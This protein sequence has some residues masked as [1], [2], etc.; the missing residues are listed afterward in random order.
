MVAFRA[1][2]LTAVLG[3]ASQS[4]GALASNSSAPHPHQ[5]LI[6]RLKL[7]GKLDIKLSAEDLEVIESGQLWMR[8]GEKDS[9]GSGVG[10]RD[11]AAPMD[12]VFGQISD[13]QGY[14][15]KVPMLNSL[16]VYDRKE[17]SGIVVEKATYVIRVIPGYNFEYYVKHYASQKEGIVLFY[18]D[19]DRLGDFNDMQGKWYLEPHPTKAGW[20]RVYY[21][22]DLMLFGYAPKIVK[23][24]LTSKGLQS[25]I[26]WVK[27]ESE[28]RAPKMVA[29]AFVLGAGALAG[30]KANAPALSSPEALGLDRFSEEMPLPS[31]GHYSFAFGA[32]VAA[33]LVATAHVVA[34]RRQSR[35]VRA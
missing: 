2:V 28:K 22:C 27:A 5:G 16:K 4:R 15:G 19:Y 6:P 9:I 26:A 14:V 1:A 34:G 21:Q 12:V 29:P 33:T 17:E 8:A 18:L 35:R 32:A 31:A 23:T 30:A 13:L 10:V 7:S 11:V 24:L 25:A 20:T 3:L